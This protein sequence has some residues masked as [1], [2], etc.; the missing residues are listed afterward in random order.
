MPLTVW[1]ITFTA[2]GAR[3]HGDDRPTVDREHNQY[4][5]PYLAPDA[6]RNRREHIAMSEFAVVFTLEQ[7]RAIEAVIPAICVRGGWEPIVCAAA[8]DHVHTLLAC[9]RRLHGKDVRPIFKRWLT[10]ALDER[11]QTP[12][13]LDGMSWWTEGGSTKAVK[14][15]EYFCNAYHYILRQRATRGS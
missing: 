15:N 1:H 8:T 12:K 6:E 3:L 2:Y 10:Q 14:D 9:E 13:R 7:R 11:W 4:G 5:T